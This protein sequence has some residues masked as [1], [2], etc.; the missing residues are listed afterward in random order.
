[1]PSASRLVVLSILRWTY[2]DEW[3]LGSLSHRDVDTGTERNEQ[4]TQAALKGIAKH[5]P[6]DASRKP[7]SWLVV[8]QSECECVSSWEAPGSSNRFMVEGLACLAR[9]QRSLIPVS[10]E[11]G[12]LL[13]PKGA[14]PLPACAHSHSCQCCQQPTCC[15]SVQS[16]QATHTQYSEGQSTSEQQQTT[17]SKMVSSLS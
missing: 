15:C 2:Q 3:N 5:G 4:R 13:D 6:V 8:Q 10:S 12:G 11:R 9:L 14:K 17:S 1:M 16:H 7:S